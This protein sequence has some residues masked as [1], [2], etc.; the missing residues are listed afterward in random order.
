MMKYFALFVFWTRCNNVC[1]KTR[2]KIRKFLSQILTLIYLDILKYDI[3][4]HVVN[5]SVAIT[6]HFRTSKQYCFPVCL[7]A[8]YRKDCFWLLVYNMAIFVLRSEKCL[9]SR[10]PL[11]LKQRGLKTLDWKTIKIKSLLYITKNLPVRGDFF[12]WDFWFYK[13]GRGRKKVI[14]ITLDNSF[15][16]DLTPY[17]YLPVE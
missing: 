16:R 10:W 6:G 11:C 2:I 5:S 3:F 1:R 12:N 4:N 9:M 13:T 17:S 15:F 14:W 7:K 8:R